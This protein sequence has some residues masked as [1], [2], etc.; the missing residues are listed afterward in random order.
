MRHRP[1]P[2]RIVRLGGTNICRV[3]VFT[4]KWWWRKE[5][6]TPLTYLKWCDERSVWEGT[7]DEAVKRQKQ[8][9]AYEWEAVYRAEDN[10]I[11]VKQD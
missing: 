10:W 9:I 7:Y 8:F 3:E 1:R 5:R 2:T 4:R 6:W 11:V